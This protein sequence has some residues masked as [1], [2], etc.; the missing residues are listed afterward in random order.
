MARKN[1]KIINPKFDLAK[2]ECKKALQ[3]GVLGVA[4]RIEGLAAAN[5]P[6]DTGA[7]R[8]SIYSESAIESNREERIGEAEE[9]YPGP[10]RYR[11][12]GR[13]PTTRKGEMPLTQEVELNGDLQAKVAVREA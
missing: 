9:K 10:G 12:D 13:K 5:A 2:A 11:D 3:A 8:A 1:I 7:L 4:Q 6:I